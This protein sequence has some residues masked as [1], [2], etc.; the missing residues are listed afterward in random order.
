[1][2][3]IRSYY[4]RQTYEIMT[5]EDVGWTTNRIVLGKLSGR[6]AFKQRLK[7]ISYNFV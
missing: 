2:Y 7:E 5:A 4:A 1:M 3:A 6:S